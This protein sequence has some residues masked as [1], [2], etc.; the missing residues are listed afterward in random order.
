MS[1]SMAT[2]SLDG[3]HL[4]FEMSKDGQDIN[5]LEVIPLEEK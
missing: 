2:E 1:T 5:P 3:N 4:H